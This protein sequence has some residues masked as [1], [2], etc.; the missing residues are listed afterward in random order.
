[1]KLFLSRKNFNYRKEVDGQLLAQP[2]WSRCLSYEYEIRKDAYKLCR[3]RAFGI[4]EALN[5]VVTD[6]EHRTQHWVQLIAIANSSGA[7]D[8]SIA[9]LEKEVELLK[10]T[11]QRSRSPWMRPRRAL[12][13]SQQ[14]LALPAPSGSAS[15]AQ[16]KSSGARNNRKAK[17][18]GGKGSSGKKTESTSSG[19]SF[20][21]IMDMGPQKAFLLFLFPG[22]RQIC[23]KLQK[24][25]CSDASVCKR[26]HNCIGCNTEG[27]PYDSCRC[28]QSKFN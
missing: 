11:M 21:Q 10:S 12:Q 26:K 5:Q 22:H 4:S 9:C 25:Q 24:H 19:K 20:Q 17:G 28:L 13:P 14:M 3:L 1:M 16:P 18:A 27:K 2:C 7:N 6:N 15:S 23:W 8:A